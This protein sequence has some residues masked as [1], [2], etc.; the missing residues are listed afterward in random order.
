MYDVNIFN[1]TSIHNT[2][3]VDCKNWL[4]FSVVASR[5][6]NNKSTQGGAISAKSEADHLTLSKFI[7]ESSHF[8]SNMAENAGSI[9][10]SNHIM[11]IRNWYFDSNKATIGDGGSLYLSCTSANYCEFDVY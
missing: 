9:Y 8:A 2:Q 1:G 10:V 7:V 6:F 11:E 4:S 5:F 3:V